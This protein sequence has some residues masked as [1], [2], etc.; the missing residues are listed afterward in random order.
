MNQ[1]VELTQAEKEANANSHFFVFG[2]DGRRCIDCD[3]AAWNATKYPCIS[4]RN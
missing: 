2:E 3:I 4:E 1:T